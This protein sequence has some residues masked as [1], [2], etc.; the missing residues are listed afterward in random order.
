MSHL[1][2]RTV[3]VADGAYSA[4]TRYNM[5]NTS[6]RLL[7]LKATVLT[8]AVQLQSMP[9]G[10]LLSQATDQRARRLLHVCEVC[11]RT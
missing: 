5:L 6:C 4:I 7:Q 2:V 10:R 9:A 1:N 3:V 11:S 8:V